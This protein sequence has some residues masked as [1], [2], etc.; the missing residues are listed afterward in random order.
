M[1][2]LLD[3][4]VLIALLVPEHVHHEVVITHL[5]P[6]NRAVATC[7]ITQGAFMRLGLREGRSTREVARSLSSLTTST[8]HYFVADD[9][10]Y[11]SIVLTGVVGHRQVTD[12]YLVGL[13]RRHDL[14]LVTLDKGLAALHG[15]VT[16]LVE[17]WLAREPSAYVVVWRDG[18]MVDPSRSVRR[19]R[20][21]GADD[22]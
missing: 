5:D 2:A 9:L 19:V 22:A 12:A 15:D 17:P 8:W 10:G 7:P 18:R 20:T 14:P 16:E 1:T 6:P 3:A 11:E 21:V 13:A 4:N